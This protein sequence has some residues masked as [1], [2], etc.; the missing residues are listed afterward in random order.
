M[1]LFK[2]L[3]LLEYSFEQ[4]TLQRG[5]ASSNPLFLTTCGAF[6]S[7]CDH[8]ESKHVAINRRPT[9]MDLKQNFQSND[10]GHKPPLNDHPTP[11]ARAN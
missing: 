1:F 5:H 4:E 3:L 2:R 7:C 11:L 9:C 8:L 6:T 10:K